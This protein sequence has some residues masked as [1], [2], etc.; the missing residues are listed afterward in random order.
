MA[1]QNA[2]PSA[3]S[4]DGYGYTTD[5]VKVNPFNFGLNAGNCFLT[6]FEWIPN[7]GKD[8]AEQEAL[9]IVFTINGTEKSYRKFPVTKA[10]GKDNAEV[11]DPTAPEMKEA[12]SDFNAVI[13]HILHCFMN[14]DSIKA[15]MNVPIKDFKHYCQICMSI[16]P[17]TYKDTA[18]DIFLQ[19]GWNLGDKEKT[20][21]EIPTKMKYGRWLSVAQNPVGSTSWKEVRVENPADTVREALY[22][23]DGANNKHLFIK[24]GWFMNSNFANQQRADG[25]TTDNSASNS[26]ASANVTSVTNTPA[27]PTKQAASW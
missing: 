2:S 23:V 5:E 22:Y 17:K 12:M 14:S 10:F 15:A 11:T 3:N 27:G 6:K 7:G 13:V 4:A 19:W 21:L 20:Y 24:N 26:S 1:D 8:G 9:D 18:L 16:L 25:G